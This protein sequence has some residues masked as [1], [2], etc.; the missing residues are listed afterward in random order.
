MIYYREGIED[1]CKKDQYIKLGVTIKCG[2]LPYR[3]EIKI[4]SHS[5]KTVHNFGELTEHYL[6]CMKTSLIIGQ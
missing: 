6:E 4:V 1:I 2:G 3:P 5:V